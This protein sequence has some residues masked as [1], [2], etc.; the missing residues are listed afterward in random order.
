MTALVVLTVVGIGAGFWLVATGRRPPSGGV[1]EVPVPPPT[2]AAVA[3][4]IYFATGRRL[5]STP[6]LKQDLIWA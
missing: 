5:R 4:A 2:A 1:A 6:I 3:N